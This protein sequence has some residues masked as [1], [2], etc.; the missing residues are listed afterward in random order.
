MFVYM[1]DEIQ[2]EISKTIH[3]IFSSN[4]SEKCLKESIED[5]M[6]VILSGISKATYGSTTEEI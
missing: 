4:I 3:A 1:S 6:K 2:G 5:S